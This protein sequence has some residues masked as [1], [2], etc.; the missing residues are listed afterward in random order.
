MKTILMIKVLYK[1][2]NLDISIKEM[3]NFRDLKNKEGM[4]LF[5]LNTDFDNQGKIYSDN[6]S[7]FPIKQDLKYTYLSNAN[8]Y[9][10]RENFFELKKKY[11]NNP[12]QLDLIFTDFFNK[13][14]KDINEIFYQLEECYNSTI[15]SPEFI[16]KLIGPISKFFEEKNVL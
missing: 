9:F 14:I 10:V 5:N 2:V 1:I 7:K 8:C 15:K 13:N 16:E 11:S 4:V 12:K 3:F 6:K